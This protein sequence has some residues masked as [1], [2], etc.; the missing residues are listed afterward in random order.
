MIKD[1]ENHGISKKNQNQNI[2]S[3][4]IFNASYS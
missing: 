3:W 2:S 4:E 1:E